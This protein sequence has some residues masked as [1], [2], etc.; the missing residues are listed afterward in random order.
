MR[1]FFSLFLL[2]AILPSLS[3]AGSITGQITTATQG[4]IA[5]GTLTLTLTQSAVLAGSSLVATTSVACYTDALG[6]V[7]GEPTPIVAPTVSTN[8]SSGTLAAGTYYVKFTY[9]D[10]S[11]ESAPSVEK[12]IILSSQGTL[13]TTP[14]VRQPASAT[15]W[16][17]YIGTSS[18]AETLQ[19]TQVGF[20]STYQQSSSLAA[21]S[22]LPSSHTTVCKVVF[23][24]QLIPSFTGYNVSFSSSS[25]SL[26]SGFPQRW[27]LQGGASGTVNLSN[28][29]PLYSGVT[30]YPQAIVT[31]PAG[32]G[33]QS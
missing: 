1:K 29:T 11:G 5:N 6:N 10:G 8:T 4:P 2:L 27:Y 22:A 7:V 32:N 20:T 14:P 15:G 23:N 31:N 28:G 18:G 19:S 13:L 9:Y 30:Q 12:V 25:G 24:D 33:Q 16:K 21:G 3:F 17:V 26:V